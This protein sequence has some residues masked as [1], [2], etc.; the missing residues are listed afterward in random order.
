M[1]PIRIKL[2]PIG[3]KRKKSCSV[4]LKFRAFVKHGMSEIKNIVGP[5]YFPL[6]FV[7]CRAFLHSPPPPPS[8]AFLCSVR[9]R[10]WTRTT[11]SRR[12][13]AFTAPRFALTALA[14]WRRTSEDGLPRRRRK[15]SAARLL[16][17]Q[18]IIINDVQSPRPHPSLSATV[19]FTLASWNP[20]E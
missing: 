15:V 17:V 2:S 10:I 12:T 1:A 4:S 3:A 6:L 8:R 11:L 16:Y 14:E 19:R 20:K 7:T 5:F 13:P 9:V 18:H